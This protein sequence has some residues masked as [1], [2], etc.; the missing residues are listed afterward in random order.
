MLWG[1]ESSSVDATADTLG[2]SPVLLHSKGPRP[3]RKEKDV[4]EPVVMPRFGET[5]DSCLLVDWHVDVGEHVEQG[6]SIATIETDKTEFDVEAPVSGTVLQL[7]VAEGEEAPVLS[8][9]A[10]IGDPEEE[11]AL[12]SV[13]VNPE[14]PGLASVDT[15]KHVVVQTPAKESDP[16]QATVSPRSSAASPRAQRAA[17]AAG[18]E[19]TDV[20]GTGPHGR[21]TEEDVQKAV[22]QQANVIRAGEGERLEPVKGVR[23]V[24]ALRMRESLA[25]TAQFTLMSSF[26]ATSIL[27]FREELRRDRGSG[28]R[29]PTVTDLL[30]HE[31][32]RSLVEHPELNA[33]FLGDS[34]AYYDRV[35]LGIAVDTPRGLLVPV[36][37]GAEQLDLAEISVEAAE[38]IRQAREGVISPDRLAGGTFTVSN[39]G[40][41]GVEYFTPILNSPQVAILGVGAPVLRPVDHEGVIRNVRSIGLS[42]TIDH[43]AVDGGTAA[44]FLQDLV[45]RVQ[46]RRFVG[47]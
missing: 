2:M 44:K 1:V 39:L 20:A 22:A 11:A 24:T 9:I 8:V 29:I 15:A 16:G 38:L 31:V 33:R 43:Q 46:R 5:V 32:A 7:L 37:P 36:L 4:P 3:I 12:G 28:D 34:I 40:A 10:L 18:I 21:I 27:E 13:D 25:T 17:L 45:T 30:L 42:L 14:I 23:K 35:D 41:T 26:D 6:A 47:E 19:L